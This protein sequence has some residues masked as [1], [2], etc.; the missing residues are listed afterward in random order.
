MII[1]TILILLFSNAVV[2][3]RD[4]S[5]IFNR[6]AMIALNYAILNDVISLSFFDKGLAIHGG[7]LYINNVTQT[8]H[9]IIYII[10]ILT[11]IST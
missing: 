3:R 7:L 1:T 2:L 6:I 8:F 4:T 9:V 11:N 5:I 10:T